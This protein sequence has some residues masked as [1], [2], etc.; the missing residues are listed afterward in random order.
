MEIKIAQE[1]PQCGA[2]IT[3]SESDR[4][5]SCPYCGV[6]SF[7]QSTGAF[8]Y[9]L[10]AQAG[11][12]AEEGLLH[13][14]YIRFKGN[15][16]LVNEAGISHKVMDVTQLGFDLPGLPPSLG[17]RPQ[18]M[19][20][21]RVLPQNQ[22][23]YLR[24]TT[25]ARVILEKVVR[26]SPMRI[27]KI[28]QTVSEKEND[29][30]F[31]GS[32]METIEYSS[33]SRFLHRAFI[34]ETVSFVYLPIAVGETEILDGVTGRFLMNTEEASGV[35]MRGAPFNPRWQVQF[36]PTLCPRCGWTLDG[37]GDCLVMTCS[38]CDTAWQLGSHALE[39]VHWQLVPGDRRTALYLGFWKISTHIPILDI[40]SFADFIRRTNQ[41]MIAKQEWHERVMSF[42]VPAFKLQ[43]KVFLRTGRQATLG[44]W[45]L[46]PGPGN[47]VPNLYPVTLPVSEAKQAV[48]VILA[49]STASRKNIFP[50]LPEIRLQDVTTQL[51]FLP[52]VDKGHDWYQPHTAVAISKNILRFSRSL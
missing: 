40:Y 41:A 31:V 1:C 2:P 10:P 43:P 25:K 38:N 47:V 11:E 42:W 32:R 37:E 5:L 33:H 36:M 14:P 45:R 13:V 18:A 35:P 3:I 52:F 39:Q 46:S 26:L 8:R 24:L 4:L 21:R 50:Y 9:S 34:G 29:M 44:Q 49:A 16:F 6:K 20:V 28:K 17:V 27:E 48:K 15:V 23:R 51:V 12:K 22:G 7:M 30:V 19:Q